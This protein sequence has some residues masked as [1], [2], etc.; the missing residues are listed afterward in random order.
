MSIYQLPSSLTNHGWKGAVEYFAK[1]DEFQ[2]QY[3][4]ELVAH[5]SASL[6]SPSCV[7]SDNC[8]SKPRV[9][10][11]SRWREEQR[12][13]LM[14]PIGARILLRRSHHSGVIQDT[15]MIRVNAV[16]RWECMYVMYH[17]G[18]AS[19]VPVPSKKRKCTDF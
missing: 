10:S 18:E 16:H 9:L 5:E 2:R 15:M 14:A 1:E 6:K 8:T 11:D 17:D 13:R 12:Y 3:D 7:Y 19:P 4:A